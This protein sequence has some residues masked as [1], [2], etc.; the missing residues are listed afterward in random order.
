MQIRNVYCGVRPLC[1]YHDAVTSIQSD[2][3]WKSMPDLCIAASSVAAGIHPLPPVSM[4]CVTGEAMMPWG[5]GVRRSN[6]ESNAVSG[7]SLGIRCPWAVECESR[8]ER[9]LSYNAK[10][11]PDGCALEESSFIYRIFWIWRTRGMIDVYPLP[12]SITGMR[13]SDLLLAR[14]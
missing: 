6:A 14:L 9:N 5:G 2:V 4:F 13:S 1:T 3:V 11:L 8:G 10:T 7:M 12:F